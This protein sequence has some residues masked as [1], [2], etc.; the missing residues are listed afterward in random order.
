MRFVVQG[1]SAKEIKDALIKLGAETDTVNVLYS[2]TE[3][4]K[5][6][7]DYFGLSEKVWAPTQSGHAN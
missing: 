3:G 6:A 5:G 1:E 7:L 2:E 4:N